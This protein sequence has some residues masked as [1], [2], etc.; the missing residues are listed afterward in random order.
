M[1]SM[2]TTSQLGIRS[3]GDLIDLLDPFQA[4]SRKS[5]LKMGAGERITYTRYYL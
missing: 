4:C 2:L 3:Y 5:L 1:P